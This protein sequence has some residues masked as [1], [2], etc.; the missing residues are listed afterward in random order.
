MINMTSAGAAIMYL[1]DWADIFTSLVRCFTETTIINMSVFSALG[2]TLSWAY[3]R[4]YVFPYLI[5]YSCFRQDMY[6]GANFIGD[7]FLGCLLIILYILHV[8][9]FILLIKSIKRF[10]KVGKADDLQ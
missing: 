9:W 10:V 1:H 8:Y 6:H 7:K 5:Y 3:T 4:L 2:M